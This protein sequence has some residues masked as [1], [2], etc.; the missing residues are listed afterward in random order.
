[1]KKLFLT[2]AIAVF[3]LVGANAQDSGFE[4]GVFVGAP[5]G[6]ADGFSINAGA[7]FGYYFEVIENLKIGGI[8]GVDHFFGKDY[9][10]GSV[11]I[12]GDGATFIPIAASAK[13]T[14]A[15]QFFAGLDL[16]YD[17]GVSDGAGDGGFLYRPRVGWSTSMVDLY[18]YYKGISYSYDYG[19]GL[20]DATWSVGSVGVGA[21]FKF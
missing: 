8:V 18:A 10:Y 19:Y 16:G 2:A 21:A 9:D 4:A 14:F 5:I 12:E 11:T 7:T 15:E 3:G 6:D 20:G 1:M 17:I 13:Y